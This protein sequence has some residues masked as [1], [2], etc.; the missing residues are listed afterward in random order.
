MLE[1]VGGRG[2][3]SRLLPDQHGLGAGRPRPEIRRVVAESQADLEA[4]FRRMIETGQGSGEIRAN[5]NPAATA[6]GLLAALLG[7]LVLARSR[8]DRDLLQAVADE[9]LRRLK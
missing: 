1:R 9:A 5:L 6:R 2:R 4:F 8:P 3:A 7:L